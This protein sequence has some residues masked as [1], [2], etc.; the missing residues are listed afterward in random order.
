MFEPFT[1]YFWRFVWTFESMLCRGSNIQRESRKPV[2]GP[3][4]APCTI[5]WDSPRLRLLP[6]VAAAKF[7]RIM[8][9]GILECSI[10]NSCSGFL[11]ERVDTPP[12]RYDKINVLV[13]NIISFSVLAVVIELKFCYTLYDGT[14]D[15]HPSYSIHDVKL[16]TRLSQRGRN[17]RRLLLKESFIRD[18]QLWL[19]IL[20]VNTIQCPDT[21][22]SW[23]DLPVVA[24]FVTM[25]F[26]AWTRHLTVNVLSGSGLAFVFYRSVRKL[27]L[28]LT[29]SPCHLWP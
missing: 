18:C 12:Y 4:F 7:I 6:L 9:I 10:R 15:I 24:R 16:G 22:K 28:T 29:H 3:T 1:T 26:N 19:S 21:H 23:W 2:P 20:D 11:S 25:K 17:P 14:C 27:T 5:L 8:W 13:G